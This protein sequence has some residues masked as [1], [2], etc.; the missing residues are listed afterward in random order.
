M[1]QK[2]DPLLLTEVELE[3]MNILWDLGQGGVQDI[4]DNLGKQRQLAYTSAAT[5]MRILEEKGFVSSTK[6][7]RMYCYSPN[8]SK[9]AHQSRLLQSMAHK[10]FDDTPVNMV[11]RL[12]E[13]EELSKENLDAIRKMLDAKTKSE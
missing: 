6:I 11:A 2:K 1:R 13:D 9:Q 5:I 8:L 12:I 3:F 4:L 7:S 10:A